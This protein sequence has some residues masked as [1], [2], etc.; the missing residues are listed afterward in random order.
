MDRL[1]SFKIQFGDIKVVIPP[2]YWSHPRE[3]NSCCEMCP[4]HIGRSDSDTDYVIGSALTNAF[5]SQFDS[6]NNR[7]S[8]A[9]KKNHVDDGLELYNA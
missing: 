4:T 3:V 6:E 9:M 7:I 1:T 2:S 8:L 5:Y